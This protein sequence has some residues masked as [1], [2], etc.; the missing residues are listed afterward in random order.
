MFNSFNYTMEAFFFFIRLF[1]RE[2]EA[3]SFW[4]KPIFCFTAVKIFALILWLK[5]HLC[6]AD[7]ES[8]EKFLAN[9]LLASALMVCSTTPI[10]KI[11][12]MKRNM[13]KGN[14]NRIYQINNQQYQI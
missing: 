1:C 12:I 10:Q 13:V 9:W 4:H 6:R 14:E 11:R 8:A 3:S 2:W 5:A 7:V